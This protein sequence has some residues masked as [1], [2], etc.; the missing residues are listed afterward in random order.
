MRRSLPQ[1]DRGAADLMGTLLLVV[2]VVALGSVLAVV[3]AAT[4]NA[5]AVTP[6]AY[7]LAPVEPGDATL[8]I[9]YQNGGPVPLNEL[10]V[11]LARGTGAAADVPASSWSAPGGSALRAGDDF[12]FPLSPAAGAD[13]VLRVTI[14]QTTANAVAADLTQR[15]SAGPAS[16]GAATLTPT[17]SPPG[18]AAD[19]VSPTLL[20]VQV[21]HPL[22]VLAVARIE[23]DLA[24]LY[25]ASGAPSVVV[26][27][28]DLGV[29]GDVQGGDGVWSAYVHAP[30]TT[31]VGYYP[32]HVN[33][34]DAAGARAASASVSVLVE[35][36]LHGQRV[37]EGTRF[38]VPS[39]ASMSALRMRNWS[40]DALHPDRADDDAVLVRI[41]DATR[42]WSA[43]V[44]IGLCNAAPC[45]KKL[46]TWN[47][48]A[49]TVYNP[50]GNQL[51]STL[52]LDLLN[53]VASGA[54]T[55]A[56]GS[57]NPTALYPAAGIGANATFTLMTMRDT[58][59]PGVSDKSLETGLLAVDLVVR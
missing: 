56:S 16:L 5:P 15:A 51:L 9:R 18:I 40:V 8:T 11:L 23:A 6:G 21:S 26:A 36:P 41:S 59:T 33:A 37:G 58:T 39:S 42:A 13:E 22:G 46:T 4:L 50:V 48:A 28:N 17:L 24:S 7:A 34:T 55:F 30:A 52:D 47:G 53:P 54:W 3:V 38:L 31:P 57:A 10:R 49:E 19:G 29:E 25:R 27:L 43:H 45:A 1:A 20:T 44:E 35:P 2:V 32:V 12:T 14:L